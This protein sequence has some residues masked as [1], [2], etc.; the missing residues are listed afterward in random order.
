MQF[1]GLLLAITLIYLRKKDLSIFGYA[2]DIKIGVL[3]V[4]C[5]VL[6]LLVGEMALREC[7][8]DILNLG[9]RVGRLALASGE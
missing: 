3:P 7:G 2:F 6:S 8:V 1:L 9:I 4:E 5:M